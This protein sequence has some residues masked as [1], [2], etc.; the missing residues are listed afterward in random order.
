MK[1]NKI[2]FAIALLLIVGTLQVLQSQD[3]KSR[4]IIETLT[5]PDSAS[6]ATVRIYGDKRIEQLM[7]NR[8]TNGN[9]KQLTMN[10]FRVQVFSSNS[11]RTA[12]TEAFKIERQ[13][14]D[15]FPEQGV[16]INYVS[17]F[18]KV[19]VGDFR[20]QAQAHAFRSQLVETLPQF[21]GEIYIV[22]EQIFVSSTK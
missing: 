6:N 11:Q 13:I 5:T 4:S 9:G 10:G 8:K 20:T 18:W 17:P 12:K 16:Y 14:L 3:S 7:T 1:K 22:K 21:R 19:R 2:P 15:V